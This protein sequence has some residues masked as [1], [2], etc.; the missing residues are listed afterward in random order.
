MESEQL[1]LQRNILEDEVFSWAKE[2][3]DPAEQ[4]SKARKHPRNLTE[5]ALYRQSPKSLMLRM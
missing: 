5:C 1:L 4:I 3:K 2:R